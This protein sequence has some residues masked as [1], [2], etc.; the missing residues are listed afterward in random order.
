MDFENIIRLLSST[1]SSFE[2]K[3]HDYKGRPVD[4][5]VCFQEPHFPT[6]APIKP[7]RSQV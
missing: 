2:V 6:W 7:G 3:D 1:E 5:V 4:I